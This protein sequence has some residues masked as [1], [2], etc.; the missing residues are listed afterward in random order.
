M[1]LVREIYNAQKSAME[2]SAAATPSKATPSLDDAEAQDLCVKLVDLLLKCEG[3]VAEKSQE[4]KG[5]IY[6]NNAKTS[7]VHVCFVF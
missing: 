7:C 5:S 6:Q 3:K 1:E 4:T 2:V